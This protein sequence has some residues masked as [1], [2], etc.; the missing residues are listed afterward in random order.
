MSVSSL[1][2]VLAAEDVE[3]GLVKEFAVSGRT[4]ILRLVPVVIIL[5]GV[6]ATGRGNLMSVTS[7]LFKIASWSAG[8]MQ[9]E[10]LSSL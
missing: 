10:M 6:L 1:L 3:G 8:M 7:E 9:C 2:E 5:G 4:G